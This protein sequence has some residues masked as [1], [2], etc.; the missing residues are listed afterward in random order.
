MTMPAGV[1]SASVSG[2]IA[3]V[4]IGPSSITSAPAADKTRLQSRLSNIYPE[5]AC[6]ASSEC[7]IWLPFAKRHH[8]P[9]E[10]GA[11]FR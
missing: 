2:A 1:E 4:G 9:A 8:A 10:L 3:G 6:P 5:C 7:G 11:E